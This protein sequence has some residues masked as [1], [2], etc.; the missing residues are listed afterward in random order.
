MQ[1][2][3]VATGERLDMSRVDFGLDADRAAEIWESC[4]KHGSFSQPVLVCMADDCLRIAPEASL[5]WPVCL[6]QLSLTGRRMAA[7][8]N[9]GQAEVTSEESDDHKYGIDVWAA[10]F[11]LIGLTAKVE[12]R[13]ATPGGRRTADLLGEGGYKTIAQEIQVSKNE[14][15][16]LQRRMRK[17]ELAGH[18]SSWSTTRNSIVLSTL[19]SRFPLGVTSS[20]QFM[21]YARP[22]DV[23][24]TGVRSLAKTPCDQRMAGSKWHRDRY[25]A[26]ACR[27]WHYTPGRLRGRQVYTDDE[28]T[29]YRLPDFLEGIATPTIVPATWPFPV[30]PTGLTAVRSKPF[31]QRHWLTV[32]DMHR[33]YESE[34]VSDSEAQ[35]RAAMDMEDDTDPRAGEQAHRSPIPRQDLIGAARES[36]TVLSGRSRCIRC[37]RPFSLVSERPSGY[38]WC[39]CCHE[40]DVRHHS[41]WLRSGAKS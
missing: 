36:I 22:E 12:S 27:G 16:A 29:G 15:Q 37:S 7:H 10:G 19:Q 26:R 28:R 21:D 41:G 25:L 5:G 9:P 38:G 13:Y 6:K 33:L 24:L 34:S 39:Y 2:V 23:M 40:D 17:D 14:L 1:P 31:P 20:R 30:A 4:Y 8:L 11:E 3:V 32:D 18:V 35:D